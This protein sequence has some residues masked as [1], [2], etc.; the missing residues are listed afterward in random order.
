[1]TSKIMTTNGV[2][3]ERLVHGVETGHQPALLASARVLMEHASADSLVNG[4]DGNLRRFTGGLDIALGDLHISRLDGRAGAR[5][6]HAVTLPF[7][8][9]AADALHC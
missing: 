9:V 7:A 1:M 8:F 4:F 6:H 5:P 2:V 3:D